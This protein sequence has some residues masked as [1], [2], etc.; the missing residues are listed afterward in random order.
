MLNRAKLPTV[1]GKGLLTEAARTATDL[2]NIVVST[3][4]PIASYNGF[5]KKELPG[6]RNMRTFGK[7]RS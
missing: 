7:S 3:R 5:F 2:E 4:K 6:L 1:K